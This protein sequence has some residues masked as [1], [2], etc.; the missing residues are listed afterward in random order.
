MAIKMKDIKV[1]RSKVESL[2][3]NLEPMDTVS[4][5]GIVDSVEDG[6][7]TILIYDIR[8]GTSKFSGSTGSSKIHEM[9]TLEVE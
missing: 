1:V 2:G 3:R 7:V 5:S 4:L 9:I 6:K 8:V